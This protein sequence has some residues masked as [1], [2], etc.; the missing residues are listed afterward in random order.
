MYITKVR[1]DKSYVEKLPCKV[2]D[3]KLEDLEVWSYFLSEPHLCEETLK[4][5]QNFHQTPTVPNDYITFQDR[6]PDLE[7]FF[8]EG[9]ILKLKSIR[10][11]PDDW[12]ITMSIGVL[13]FTLDRV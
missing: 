5:C 8:L 9:K 3:I 10:P 6:N 12:E 11:L 13:T 1:F 2:S 7:S 4:H